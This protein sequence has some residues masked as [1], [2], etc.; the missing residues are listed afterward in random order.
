MYQTDTIKCSFP[1]MQ[2]FLLD[3]RIDLPRD[4]HQ[5][6]LAII[7]HCFTCSKETLTSFRVSRGLAQRGIGVLR[8]DFTGLG[9]S[10][11]D[12]ADTNFTTMVGDILCAADYLERHQGP[13]ATL[14]GHSMGGTAALLASTRLPSC[15]TVVTIA[16]PSQPEHVLHHFGEAMEKLRARQP[17]HITVAGV[18]YPVRP[19]F[20]D[21]VR[22]Y[23]MDQQ[24]A[25]YKRRILAIRAGQDRL[26]AHPD[27]E[28]IISY[29]SGPTALIDLPGADHLFSARRDTDQ[30][31]DAIARWILEPG[32]V[33]GGGGSKENAN[34]RE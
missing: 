31:I 21:D 11:G 16:S 6:P 13:A 33:T 8:F 2:G 30:L 10:G 34:E 18:D 3:A 27:A 29:S 12:F 23:R 22:G 7:S 25:D 17:A 14:I 15:D 32:M 4:L 28:E 19:Q 9:N 26:V 1:G 20:I 24:L 5:P